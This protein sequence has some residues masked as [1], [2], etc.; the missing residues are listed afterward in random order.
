MNSLYE[1]FGKTN[2]NDC[3]G[4]FGGYQNFLQAYLDFSKQFQQTSNMTPQQVVQQMLTSGRMSKDQFNQ[5]S[6][7]ANMITGR[8]G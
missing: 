5:Y 6:M 1:R 2:Q 8:K 7:I 3:Y 4:M